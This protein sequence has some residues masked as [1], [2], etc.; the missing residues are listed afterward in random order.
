MTTDPTRP[1]V[2]H[3][4]PDGA[5]HEQT[6]PGFGAVTIRPLDPAGDAEVVHRWVDD[7]RARFWGMVGRSRE[8]VRETYEF[9][10]S[11]DTHHAYLVLRDG[12]PAALLQTYLP[13]HDPLGE[14]YPVQDGDL[15]LH[16]LVAPAAGPLR[17]GHTQALVNTLLG[18]VFADPYVRRAV[19]EPD[20]RNER[21]V[22][23]LRASGFEIGPVLELAEKHAQLV[24]L[25]RERFLAGPAA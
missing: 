10:D 6:V 2:D 1:A 23:R 8:Q 3:R 24:H 21:S 15:G 19:A 18:F 22:A 13:E 4:A 11:L 25:T 14:H 7:E 9:V 20:V 12:E 16:L 17:H 5:R